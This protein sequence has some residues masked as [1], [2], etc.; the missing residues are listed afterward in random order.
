MH[1]ADKILLVGDNRTVGSYWGVRRPS[2]IRAVSYGAGGIPSGPLETHHRNTILFPSSAISLRKGSDVIEAVCQELSK[3]TPVGL[4]VVALGRPSNSYWRSQL[5]KWTTQYGTVFDYRGW[6]DPT[7][8][9]YA[10]LLGRTSCAVIPS[11]E[12][13][14]V[15]A[16]VEA[17]RSGIPTFTTL[18]CGLGARPVELQLR[19]DSVDH[20]AQQIVDFASTVTESGRNLIIEQQ[21]SPAYAS[22]EQVYRT[23]RNFLEEGTVHPQLWVSQEM[24]QFIISRDSCRESTS[25]AHWLDSIDVDAAFDWELDAVTYGV[26]LLDSDRKLDRV[27]LSDAAFAQTRNPQDVA[28]FVLG[29]AL[30]GAELRVQ[31]RRLTETETLVQLKRVPL[32]TS[33]VRT[34]LKSASARFLVAWGRRISALRQ[35]VARHLPRQLVCRYQAR[36]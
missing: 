28:T 27:R 13:G 14:L 31:R 2:D 16:A 20:W 18:E 30:V 8:S 15:G 23:V 1:V 29:S 11:R 3:R 22:T 35:Q 36:G 5:N 12:E 25:L 34:N 17:I 7:S 10:D 33:D 6:L 19:V 9:E 26:S 24:E 21:T 32:G 4:K